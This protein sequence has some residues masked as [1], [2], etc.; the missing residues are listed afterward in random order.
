MVNQFPLDPSFLQ[1]GKCIDKRMHGCERNE[2]KMEVFRRFILPVLEE[3]VILSAPCVC[4]SFY[5]VVQV[6]Q[7]HIHDTHA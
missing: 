6:V 4:L 7:A 2:K 5:G 1:H 3:E